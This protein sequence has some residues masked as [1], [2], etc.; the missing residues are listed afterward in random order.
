MLCYGSTGEPEEKSFRT[1]PVKVAV[2]T[3][4][5]ESGGLAG[6]EQEYCEYQVSLGAVPV[7]NIHQLYLEA[8]YA[9]DRAEVY[10]DG[11]LADDW[12][13]TGETWH[14]AL[15]RFGYPASLV[16]R[17]YSSDHPIPN[18]YGNRVYYDL[19]VEEGCVLKGVKAIPEYTM[20]ISRRMM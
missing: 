10:L 14:I 8:D 6:G 18:P 20:E 13:T 7:D 17:I 16:I 5:L 12:F 15:K 3:E 9:G 2:G 4:L 11:K 1:G 19:P